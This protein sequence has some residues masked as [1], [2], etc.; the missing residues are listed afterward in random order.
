MPDELATDNEVHIHQRHWLKIRRLRAEG[1]RTYLGRSIVR[2][3]IVTEGTAR[4]FDLAEVSRG[5]ISPAMDE[6]LNRDR[7]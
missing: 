5:P 7:E 4:C 2:R 1:G 3:G 6:G